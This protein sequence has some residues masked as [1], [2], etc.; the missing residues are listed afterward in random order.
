MFPAFAY[1]D[2]VS[3]DHAEHPRRDRHEGNC[4]ESIC[5]FTRRFEPARRARFDPRSP[6]LDRYGRILRGHEPARRDRRDARLAHRFQLAR[7]GYAESGTHGS[8]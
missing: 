4:A 1:A 8:K 6:R 7:L 3:D 2:D 5:R